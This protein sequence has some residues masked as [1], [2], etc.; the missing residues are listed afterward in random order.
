MFVVC[1]S[2]SH[3]TSYEL[4][5]TGRVDLRPIKSDNKHIILIKFLQKTG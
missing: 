3:V 4:Q 2:L 5:V 1:C